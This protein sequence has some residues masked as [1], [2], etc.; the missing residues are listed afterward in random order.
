MFGLHPKSQPDHLPDYILLAG[1]LIVTVV[2]L[3]TFSFYK[4]AVV[5][6]SI[7]LAAGYAVWGI[8]HHKKAGHLDNKIA[9]E[10]IGLAVLMVVLMLMVAN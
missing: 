2:L 9:F 1:L 7:G 6:I 8:L 5:L 3:K 10:Y 4:L